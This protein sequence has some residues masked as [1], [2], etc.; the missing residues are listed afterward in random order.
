MDGSPHRDGSLVVRRFLQSGAGVAGLV[1][2]SAFVLMALLG[3]FLVPFPDADRHWRDISWWQDSP[4]AAPPFWVNGPW[5]S[6]SFPGPASLRAAGSRA[7]DGEDGS[8]LFSWTFPLPSVP[9]GQP[10]D[11]VLSFEGEGSVFAVVSLI[12]SDGSR[13]EVFRESLDLAEGQPGR[14]TLALG[15]SLALSQVAGIS[16]EV[17]EY[18][19]AAQAEPKPPSVLLQ[20][21]ASGLLGTDAAKRDVFTGIVLGARWAL[22]L[23][24]LVSF[25]TVVM[26]LVLGIVAACYGGIWDKAISRIYEFFSLM[27][28]LP[29]L[30]VLSAAYKPSLWSFM[31]LAL[32]FFWTRAFKTVYARALQI[33][34]EGYIEAATALGAARWWRVSR[35]VLPTLLP[36]AFAV[37][38]LSVPGVITYEASVSLLGLGDASVITWGQMLHDALVQGAVI[39]R[40]WWWILPPGLMIALMG[41]TFGLLGRGFEKTLK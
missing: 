3:P 5:N 16:I 38:A 19:G 21:R 13:K 28:L 8:K 30:I 25:L 23:G 24:V 7:V 37:M 10:R 35:H 17:A 39:N 14:V 18:L 26:G 12:Q 40:L 29:F 6:Y 27:P 2:L 31:A 9:S 22:L 36:Y 34:Q 11:A 20:G 4:A 15:P 1:L 32:L 33:K 41:L